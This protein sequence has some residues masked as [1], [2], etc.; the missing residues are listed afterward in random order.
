MRWG[1]VQDIPLPDISPLAIRL[2]ICEKRSWPVPNPYPSVITKVGVTRGGNWWSHLFF[3]KKL[4][5]F[6]SHRPVKSDDLF[7][8]VTTPTFRRRMCSF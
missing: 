4:T 7:R 2:L 1:V 8:L 6:F 5:T 3:L